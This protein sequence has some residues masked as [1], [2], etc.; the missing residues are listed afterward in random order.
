MR[1]FLL[2]TT[3]SLIASAT[4]VTQT[5]TQTASAFQ[6]LYGSLSQYNYGQYVN[7]SFSG[8]ASQVFF[9]LGFS[10]LQVVPN[11]AVTAASVDLTGLAVNF[12]SLASNSHSGGSFAYAQ[13]HGTYCD[14]FRCYGY[15]TPETGYGGS[16]TFQVGTYVLFQSIQTASH[17]MLINDYGDTSGQPS[18]YDLILNGFGPSLEA[19]ETLTVSGFFE[20]Y[21]T[22]QVVTAAYYGYST[23]Y[24]A[25]SGSLASSG[26]LSVTSEET[27]PEPST[28]ICLGAG[29]IL[30]WRRKRPN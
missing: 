27:V 12:Q 25:T 22:Y 26:L 13:Y 23:D 2:F 28:I 18:T 1:R 17:S 7:P 10:D 5:S 9:T 4:P 8:G 30:L 21:V 16:A 24:F 15:Y 29:L 20:R 14:Y 3:F 6:S 19:G 11:S